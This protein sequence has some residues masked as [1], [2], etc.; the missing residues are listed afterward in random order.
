MT[1]KV[2]LVHVSYY[3]TSMYV[4]LYC[5]SF[6]IWNQ[7]NTTCIRC[8]MLFKGKH[9][10]NS[11]NYSWASSTA[12]SGNPQVHDMQVL[13]HHYIHTLTHTYPYI[14]DIN[15]MH[16]LCAFDPLDNVISSDFRIRVGAASFTANPTRKSPWQPVDLYRWITL[17]KKNSSYGYS[18]G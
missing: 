9:L 17:E 5:L 18:N 4:I 3:G 6:H 10:T 8:V 14:V 12:A 7:L 15:S 11:C 1:Y 2:R 13:W 16:V